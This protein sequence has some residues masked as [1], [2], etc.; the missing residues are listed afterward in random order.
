MSKNEPTNQK[1]EQELAGKTYR[2]E[3]YQKT[4]TVSSGMATSHEQV[5]DAY[6]Q[7]EITEVPV[8]NESDLEN[9]SK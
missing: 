7:G 3:D 4:N 5:S 8:E 9:E 2:V 6:M 1:Q